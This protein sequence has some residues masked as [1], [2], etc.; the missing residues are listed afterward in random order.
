MALYAN[1]ILLFVT[2]MEKYIPMI[3]ETIEQFSKVSGYKIT[4]NV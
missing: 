4:A 3:M 2:Q 1:D